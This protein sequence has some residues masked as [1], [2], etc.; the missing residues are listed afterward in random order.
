MKE[1]T[2]NIIRAMLDGFTGA[3]LFRRLRR[4]GAPTHMID[5]RSVEEILAS[6]ELGKKLTNKLREYEEQKSH[7]NPRAK[8][9]EQT[10]G[11]A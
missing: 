5:P 6:G 8:N 10:S 3:G 11:Q 7:M 9:G 2:R 1:R 4:P